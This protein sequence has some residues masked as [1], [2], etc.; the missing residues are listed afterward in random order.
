MFGRSKPVVFDPYRGRRAR[1]GLPAWL[2]WLIIGLL[3]GAAGVIVAQERWLPP[4]LSAGE[5]AQLRQSFA[6]AD[7]DRSRLQ[8][9][10]ED[11]RRQLEKALAEQDTARREGEALAARVAGFDR[12][13]AFVVDALPPD[14]R[15]GTVAVRA[16]RLTVRQGSLQYSLALSHQRSGARPIPAVLRLAVTG[17]TAQGSETRVDLQ[18]VDL[19]LPPQHVASGQVP[20]PAGFTPRQATVR[21]VDANGGTLGL[22]VINVR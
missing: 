12:D 5:S 3:L 21:V 18:P 17:N 20:L 16:A 19:R 13:L 22:R 14:P 4:R 15:S 11:T 2:W 8:A 7:A 6:Q 9:E 10:L 1:G